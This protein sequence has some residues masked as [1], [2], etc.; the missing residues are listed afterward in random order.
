MSEQAQNA[1]TRPRQVFMQ[2]TVVSHK[3]NKTITVRV[4]RN[5][6]HPLYG[7]YVRRKTILMAH[8]EDNQAR[9]GDL[10]EV[11]YSRPLSKR[12][13]WRFVRIVKQGLL[14]VEGDAPPPPAA[15]AAGDG[16]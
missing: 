8:D 2:G 15:P 9:E 10:V 11:V 4:D 6:K 1:K 16:S 14:R 12:K 7:K 3:A 13:C 5:V